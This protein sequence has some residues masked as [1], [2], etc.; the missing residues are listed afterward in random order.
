MTWAGML[1]NGTSVSGSTILSRT[2]CETLSLPVFKRTSTDELAVLLDVCSA[3]TKSGEIGSVWRH[4][5]KASEEL[6]YEVAF[7]AYGG[8]YI[9]A[10]SLADAFETVYP[11]AEAPTLLFGIDGLLGRV[12]GGTP[13]S[14]ADVA[15]TI[16]DPKISIGTDAANPQGVTMSFDRTKGIVK[17][18]FNL[19]YTTES[20][21]TKTLKANYQGVVLTGWGVD[22]GCGMDG[23]SDLPA[24]AFVNGA[25][26]VSDSE[27]VSVK[28]KNRNVMVKRGGHARIVD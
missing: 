16:T 3:V 7:N 26:Y 28:D 25:F 12:A 13:A 20:G 5:D 6:S 11:G 15:V 22:C 18:A 10:N 9:A 2:G 23:S 8:L 27:T 21:A 17:G 1:P 19:P 14:V 4:T 24:L